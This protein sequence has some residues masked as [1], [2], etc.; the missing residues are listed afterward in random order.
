[1]WVLHADVTDPNKSPGYQG[2][3]ELPRLAIL[4]AAVTHG[5]VIVG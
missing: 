3:G 2:S 4:C 1:M 5:V